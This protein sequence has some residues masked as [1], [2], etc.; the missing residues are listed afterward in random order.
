MPLNLDAIGTVGD[1]VERSWHA[2]DALLYAVAV[3]AG[4]VD[5]TDELAF[6]TE[7]SRDVRQKVLPTFAV[8][9]GMGGGGVLRNVGTFN[10]AMLVHAEQAF[11]L[12]RPLRPEG[13]VRITS[14]LVDIADKG[15]GA[16]VVT[17]SEAVDPASGD[18]V[19]TTRS[20]MFIRGEGGFASESERASGSGSAGG[21]AG[22]GP[23]AK[24]AAKSAAPPV[25]ERPADHVVSYP[26]LPHQALVYRLCGDRNPLHSDPAFAALAGFDRPILHGLC[27]YG[28]TGRAL[29]HTLCGSDPARLRSMYGRF[30]RPVL[31]GDTLTISI[32][33]DDAPDGDASGGDAGGASFQTTTGDGTVVIDRGRCTFA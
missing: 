29:L 2:R 20:G 3:G 19:F 14:R 11:E 31:P 30:S 32:W 27:T 18:P 28:F 4:A 12:H 25:P 8:V 26:T 16:L 10:P 5:P 24:F 7:N 22:G 9:V 15:K 6:T 33:L 17:E 23:A 13:T 21:S 1:P